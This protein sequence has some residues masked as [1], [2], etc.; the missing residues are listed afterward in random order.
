MDAAARRILSDPMSHAVAL[1]QFRQVRVKS[2]PYALFFC[3]LSNEN[4]GV[5]AVA[6]TS[7]R[8]RL[9]ASS[10]IWNEI[11]DRAGLGSQHRVIRGGVPHSIEEIGERETNE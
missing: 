4:V 3:V 6:H 7:R 10:P 1:G 2:F 8:P 5:I 9:L 11:A